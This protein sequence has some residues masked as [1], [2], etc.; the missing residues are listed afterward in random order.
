MGKWARRNNVWRYK[1]GGTHQAPD[2]R[3]YSEH[4]AVMP[5]ALAKDHVKTWTN[6]GDLVVDPM[7][8][9][10]TTLR[11]AV[12]LGRKAVGFEIHEPYVDLMVERLGQEV[13]V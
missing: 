2:F 10:G 9:C 7:A 3:R 6:P 11:A 4:P 5:L 1:V 13:L 12:D 8:G